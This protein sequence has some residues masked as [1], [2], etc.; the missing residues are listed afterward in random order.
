MARRRLG[1]GAWIPSAFAAGVGVACSSSNAV[2]IGQIPDG[3]EIDGSIV[4]VGSDD[5]SQGSSGAGDATIGS[6]SGSGGGASGASGGGAS[7]G[8]G[9]SSSGSGNGDD[10]GSFDATTSGSSSGS[11]ASSSGGSNGGSSGSASSS[12]ASS[13][14]SASGS[15]SGTSSSGSGSSSGSSSG[16]SSGS[17]S[18][19]S[20]GASSSGGSSGSSGSSSS[21]GGSSGSSSGGGNDGGGGNGCDSGGA[22]AFKSVWTMP[23]SATPTSIAVDSAGNVYVAGLF[24]GGA[25]FGSTVLV[26]PDGAAFSNMFL[27]KYNSGGNVQF[28]KGY[29]A[30]TGIYGNPMIA[31]DAMS[32]VFMGGSFNGQLTLG[33]NSP[34]LQA[35]MIDAFAAKI[36]SNGTTLWADHFGYNGGPYAVLSVAVGPD[37]NPVVAGMAAG[38]VVI[39]GTTWTAPQSSEQPWIAK[40]STASGAVAWS[41]A[42]GGDIYSGDDIWVAVDSTNRVFLAAR[43]RSGGGSWGDEP[44]AAAS[45]GGTLRAGFDANGNIMWGQWDYGAYPVAAAIDSHGRF[46]VLLNG[47]GT[48]TVGGATPFNVNGGFDTLSLLFSPTDGT[49]LSGVN[50]NNTFTFGNGGAVDAHGNAFVTGTYWPLNGSIGVGGMSFQATGSSGDHPVFVAG[51]DGLSHG[52]AATTLGGGNSAQPGAIA[53][54]SVTGNVY[55]G[56][57]NPAAFSSSIGTLQAGTYLA[58]F[59]PD[60]CDDG[61]GPSGPS[62]GTP[63]N[64]GDLGPDGGSPYVPVDAGAPAACPAGGA[65]VNGAACPVARGCSYTGSE[66]CICSPKPCGDAST[67]WLCSSVANGKSCPSSPPNPGTA[68]GSD[69]TLSCQY[70]TLEGRLVAQCTGGGWETLDA[71]IVCY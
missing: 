71:Q 11:G 7:S 27:V 13:S 41:N 65:V 53:V 5:A 25:T 54:D 23:S 34:P 37:G 48:I 24:K 44:D 45:T 52:V 60:P 40:L 32:N 58:V 16:T 69:T 46:N 36:S 19:N 6:S 17:S 9:A 26:A 56:M 57:T 2:L 62:T 18:G 20:S 1:L 10:G 66:C 15:S 33:G 14:G 35:I 21:S 63:G 43:V 12:G 70:C 59:D 3:S 31:V 47:S 55:V 22:L 4:G 50:I 30:A 49:L 8:A 28:A 64:H 61:A 51:T 42:T 29:G 68:C 39:G 38:T 67:T